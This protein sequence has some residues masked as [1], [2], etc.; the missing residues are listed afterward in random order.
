LDISKPGG[1]DIFSTISLFQVTQHL[2]NAE[3]LGKRLI[4]VNLF[5]GRG[6]AARIEKVPFG[7]AKQK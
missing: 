3:S 5:L 4:P 6:S 2:R 7:L 1:L